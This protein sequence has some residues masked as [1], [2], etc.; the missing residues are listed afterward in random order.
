M[1]RDDEQ[2]QPR[3]YTKTQTGE[4][5]PLSITSDRLKPRLSP[6]PRTD[7]AID[8]G[9]AEMPRK[10]SSIRYTN[11][12]NTNLSRS[13]SPSTN[14]PI[15]RQTGSRDPDT[16]STGRQISSR[17]PDTYSTGRQTGSRDPDIY[18]TG[19]RISSRDPDAYFVERQPGQR[20]SDYSIDRETGPG[21]F[22]E[23]G[24]G[25]K[26]GPRNTG[27]QTGSRD[28][29]RQTGPR[30]TDYNTGRQTGSRDTDYTTGRQTTRNIPST[31][32]PQDTTRNLPP[33]RTRSYPRNA[34]PVKMQDRPRKR[35]HWFLPI[36]VGM[37]AML[38]LWLLGSNIVA[39]GTQV[40]NNVHYGY[41]RTFQIDAVVGHNHDSPAHPS[42][43]IAINMNRQAVVIEIM[44]G[45]VQKSV[46]YVAPVVIAG[47]GG[48]LAPVTL[49]FRDV[50]G[51]R[52][53]DMIVHIHL[54]TQDEVSIFVND[55][56]KFRPSNNNDK[57]HL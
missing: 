22:D 17:D 13:G 8:E 47:D 11:S 1:P 10:N 36:G 24:T 48:D 52:R 6:P 53:P 37:M 9:Y 23:Y 2:S 33:N 56:T 27:R 26:T 34:P 55:G 30:D 42:H 5:R 38:A 15:R 20:D 7:E 18:S 57:I 25:R 12:Y 28:T 35:V 3:R 14:S 16:Y 21:A 43:F 19:R 54:P 32:K 50:T 29:G 40:Y 4:P 46:T 45:D 51:D 31:K 44:A 39:W 41:P 49:E